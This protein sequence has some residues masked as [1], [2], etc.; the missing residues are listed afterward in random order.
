MRRPTRESG[1]EERMNADVMLRLYLV[2]HGETAQNVDMRYLGLGDEPLNARGRRQALG[3][4]RW[5]RIR[6][7]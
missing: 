1:A 6:S 5:Q 4:R 7:D 2:R 3:R